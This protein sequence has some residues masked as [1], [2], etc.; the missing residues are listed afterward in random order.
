[1][2]ITKTTMLTLI[3]TLGILVSP[4][5]AADPFPKD[6]LTE[7]ARSLYN[8][9]NYT[10]ALTLFVKLSHRYPSSRAVYRALAASA[11]NAKAYHTAVRAYEIF[12]ALTP[13]SEDAEKARA[14]LNN[15]K[16]H[17]KG[18]KSSR[19]Q[20][21]SQTVKNLDNALKNDRLHGKNGAASLLDTL[22]KRQY[23]GPEFGKY[24]TRVWQ[25]F[26]D[27]QQQLIQNYWLP[28][29]VMDV[30]VLSNLLESSMKVEQVLTRKD[31][32]QSAKTILNILELFN[33][34][35]DKAALT[36]FESTSV[37]DYRLRYLMAML[38]FKQNRTQESVALLTALN[39][40]YQK[41]RTMIRSEQIRLKDQRRI[42]DE[43]L[44]RLIETLD[45]LP[46]PQ[47][48]N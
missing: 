10:K 33:A 36:Q 17:T 20:S 37:R 29:E 45:Q 12:L 32:I 16:K 19:W 48:K 28:S 34:G 15:V 42:R 2:M 35:K 46:E 18:K 7:Q 25:L 31:Q 13:S 26:R 47:V 23:F 1:M 5:Y 8:G 4:A 41:P 11:N 27:E 38:L 9:G 44:D 3:A 43:D 39:E 24:Q 30:E 6:A 22:I 40:Q 21:I 14:E